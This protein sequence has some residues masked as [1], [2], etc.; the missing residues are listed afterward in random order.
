VR[1]RS[2]QREVRV[3]RA[4]EKKHQRFQQSQQWTDAEVIY[5]QPNQLFPLRTPEE[6]KLLN[7]TK[8]I[9]IEIVD[10]KIEPIRERRRTRRPG[11]GKEGD[12][13][14][15][16]VNTSGCR[17]WYRALTWLSIG[18]C[19]QSSGAEDWKGGVTF[20]LPPLGRKDDNRRFRMGG[21]LGRTGMGC[22]GCPSRRCHRGL[23]AKHRYG[24]TS[25]SLGW[26]LGDA[27]ECGTG[28]PGNG[29]GSQKPWVPRSGTHKDFRKNVQQEAL[30]HR[31][32]L[33]AP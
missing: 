3:K 14:V 27:S 33:R 31:K 26:F 11:R 28:K 23:H 13:T 19:R 5:A 15:V 18:R 9:E 20:H 32:P 2:I 8:V 21:Q 16:A 22:P 4:V 7:E 1:R 17:G 30:R 12:P 6:K 10:E 25:R 29:F 24:G